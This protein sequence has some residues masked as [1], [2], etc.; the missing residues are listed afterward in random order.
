[1]PILR[2][3][4]LRNF[5]NYEA[6]EWAI[7]P[8]VNL[9]IGSNAQGKTNALEAIHLLGTGRL[10]RPGRESNAI[11]SGADGYRVRGTVEPGGTV[12]G[13]D[14]SSEARKR[15]SLNDV[16]LP[17]ASDLMG[18]LPVV[19]FSPSDLEIVS[20]EPGARRL[21]LDSI[22][23]QLFPA[24][25]RHLSLFKRALEQ[26]N[27]L[28][29]LAATQSVGD[30]EFEPW[31]SE[32]AS[33]GFGIM[34]SRQRFIDRLSLATE[35]AHREIAPNE[36]LA[37]QYEPKSHAKGQEELLQ[38]V[39][40]WRSADIRRGSTS[41]GPHRDDLALMVNE[42]D[43]RTFGSQG[44]QRTVAIALKLGS[45]EVFATER[46]EP[47]MLLLDD[48]F[49]ELDRGRRECLISAAKRFSC[50]AVLTSTDTGQVDEGLLSH[51][52]VFVVQ[53]G[54]LTAQ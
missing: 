18:R 20:S 40:E 1:M 49:S 16:G 34:E 51:A 41:I 46:G 37:L 21:F 43:A 22:L 8:G 44:Q 4:S 36:C 12:L 52:A 47:P 48:V 30:S 27:A 45:L 42:A 6:L 9:L 14:H 35:A 23:A 10:L 7:A 2:T 50:Q 38:E 17:R 25:L 54:E 5:R 33:H 24:Y 11:R 39:A 28:L 53:D 15:A 32:L 26:R 13:V 19:S 31:E 3:L 29:K